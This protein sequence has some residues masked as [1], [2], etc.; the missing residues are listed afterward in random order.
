[1]QHKSLKKKSQMFQKRRTH[2]P[3]FGAPYFWGLR[4]MSQCIHKNNLQVDKN[5]QNKK[6]KNTKKPP[7]RTII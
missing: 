4:S 3:Q 1:M 7:H 2:S 6:K 5:R